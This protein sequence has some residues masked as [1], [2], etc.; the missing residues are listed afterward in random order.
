MQ[1]PAVNGLRRVL[2]LDSGRRAST[3]THDV[4]RA[5]HASA[6][7]V[8]VAVAWAW[9]WPWT[10]PRSTKRVKDRAALAK[11]IN[12]IRVIRFIIAA[13]ARPEAVFGA[14]P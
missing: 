7:A 9:T 11:L 3:G 8:V 12:L 1:A 14:R 10:G 4:E 5:R 6:V 2:G 13:V